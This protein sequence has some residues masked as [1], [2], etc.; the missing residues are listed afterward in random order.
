MFVSVGEWFN[1]L[2]TSQSVLEEQSTLVF[3]ECRSFTR[4]PAKNWCGVAKCASTPKN[5][6]AVLIEFV[7][8]GASVPTNMVATSLTLEA[9][10]HETHAFEL[11]LT[12]GFLAT[13]RDLMARDRATKFKMG[14]SQLNV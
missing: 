10:L 8:D 11:G 5:L 12:T 6:S 9:C 13:T 2:K 14:E 4:A 7:H 3:P 1:R